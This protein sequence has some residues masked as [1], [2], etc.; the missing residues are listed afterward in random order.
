MGGTC[1]E[2]LEYK[3]LKAVM[4]QNPCG[5]ILLGKPREYYVAYFLICNFEHIL[6]VF[7]PILKKICVNFFKKMNTSKQKCV[8]H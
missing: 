3:L 7:R 2:E 1:K 6:W 8:G 4:E 5:K